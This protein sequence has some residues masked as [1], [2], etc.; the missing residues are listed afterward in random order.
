[1]AEAFIAHM[2]AM[3]GTFAAS[4]AIWFSIR[5]ARGGGRREEEEGISR[6]VKEEEKIGD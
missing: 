6:D 1:M 4:T 2:Y 3:A 5:A